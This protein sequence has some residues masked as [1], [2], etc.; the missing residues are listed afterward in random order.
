MSQNFRGA[1]ITRS[2][3]R[4]ST[5]FFTNFGKSY[6]FFSFFVLKKYPQ[7]CERCVPNYKGATSTRTHLNGGPKGDGGRGERYVRKRLVF[8]IIRNFLEKY[9]ENQKN[10]HEQNV[11]VIQFYI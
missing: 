2:I 7:D 9:V 10:V 4:D 8:V 11:L 3:G 6:Y 1:S 5:L